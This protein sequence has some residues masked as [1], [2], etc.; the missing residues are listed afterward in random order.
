VYFIKFDETG[1]RFG[2]YVPLDSFDVSG[3]YHCAPVHSAGFNVLL[4]PEI[5][6]ISFNAPNLQVRGDH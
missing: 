5:V 6:E 2:T 3:N 1:N 4:V